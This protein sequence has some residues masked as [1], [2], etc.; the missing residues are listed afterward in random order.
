MKLRYWVLGPLLSSAL[1]VQVA[2]AHPNVDPAPVWS[3]SGL[4]ST[5]GDYASDTFGDPWDFANDEDV[6]PILVV[7]S[8][9]SYGISRSNAGT[10][11]LTVASVNNSTIKLVRTWGVQ[12]PWGRD[13]LLHPVDADRYT[14]ISFGMC[15]AADL[16]MAVHYWNAAGD[17]GLRPFYP[18]A[19]CATYSFDLRDT[20]GNPNGFKAPWTGTMTRLELLRGG[21]S[22]GGDPLVNITLDWVRLHRPDA[23]VTPPSGVP[24]PRV[25]TPN[26]EGGADYASQTGNPWDFNGPD[27]VV[28]MGD[29]T[30]VS[31][32]GGDL[33]GT[34]YRNDS[35]V[36]LPLRGETN[37]DRYRRATVDVCYDGPMGFA[38]APGGGMNA[39]FAWL[40]RGQARWSET[41]DII[42]FPGC[43]RMTV[44][45]STS[46]AVAV[47]DE[48]T[49]LKSGWRGQR[50]ERLRFDLNE[51]P[52]V[53]NFTLREIKMADDAAFSGTYDISFLDAAGVGGTAD[54]YVTTNRGQFDG[55][56]IAQG[57]TVQG[58]VNTFRWDGTTQG[59]SAMPN[60]TY[61]VYI[62]MSKSGMVGTATSTG[63]VRLERPVP[64]TPS[65]YV[66]ISPSRILDTRTGI[67][68]NI[69]PL[70]PQVF[71]ELDVTGVGGVPETGVTAVVMNVT[72]DSPWTEGYLTAS[73][74]GEA[75]PAVSNLNFVPWQTVP[76]LVTVKVGANGK[77]DIFNSQ[78]FTNVVADVVGYYTSTPVAGGLFTPLT[79]GR[80]LDTRNGTGR[81]GVVGAV[82][83]G[84]WIDVIVTNVAGVPSS[85]VSAVALNVTVE[86]PTANGYVTTWPTGEARPDA[87]SHN[88]TPGVNVANLV[89]A[90]VGAGGRVSL[91]NSAGRTNLIA[92]V[93]GY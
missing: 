36:E 49:T 75:R 84:D 71:T 31:Y 12:L 82:N 8:E 52:G 23:S 93:V 60:G 34:T 46:P 27:D 57:I 68:G 65:W 2:L 54:V 26:E 6:P 20:T 25:L 10:G 24:L 4:L 85:G 53:R 13:G 58:G 40:M 28:S 39:R 35:F 11:S 86:G 29:I 5:S 88:F 33:T 91:F 16:N 48:S 9:N 61:W 72:V 81:G 55:T 64:A 70:G 66:P 15:L 1:C 44:D 37:P 87:S 45:L 7:G 14:T 18:K 62:V 50:L 69:T 51:D 41:Q 78:G 83:G 3:P 80:V 42:I 47:N 76:N 92:D 73:P 32:S 22:A 56:R 77:V 30:N 89:L 79:P 59:G 90:K 67:G 63:P 43:N 19:G 17:T 74:S 21:A 38:D